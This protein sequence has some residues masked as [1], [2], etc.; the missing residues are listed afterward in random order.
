MVAIL[1]HIPEPAV[2]EPAAIAAM[3]RAFDETCTALHV[4]AGDPRGRE[5]VAARI[6]D[7]ARD[8]VIDATAL[9]ERVLRE[10]RVAA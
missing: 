8:G 1:S 4:F 7:L 6:I 2:F 5:A 10:A 9:R 3:A